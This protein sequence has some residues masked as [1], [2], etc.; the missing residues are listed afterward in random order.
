MNLIYNETKGN[1]F[2]YENEYAVARLTCAKDVYGIDKL[3]PVELRYCVRASLN[4]LYGELK[5]DGHGY[6]V[7]S[8][9]GHVFNLILGEA[10]IDDISKTV[11]DEALAS[12]EEQ[13]RELDVK[14]IAFRK[15]DGW[16]RIHDEIYEVGCTA[17]IRVFFEEDDCILNIEE[18]EK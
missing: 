14:K 3:D 13:V 18:P 5:W 2:D 16:S 10:L 8:N 17:E 15:V 1:I 4:K 11:V 12:L 7:P 6:C 9:N